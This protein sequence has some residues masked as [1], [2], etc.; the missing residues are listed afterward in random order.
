MVFPPFWPPSELF[1]A[2]YP[3]AKATFNM[4]FCSS[5]VWEASTCVRIRAKFSGGVW[6]ALATELFNL[7]CEGE[8]KS[9]GKWVNYFVIFSSFN[10]THSGHL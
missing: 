3:S 9:E 5:D 1:A 6:M 10:F 4:F 7:V 8:S 2:K